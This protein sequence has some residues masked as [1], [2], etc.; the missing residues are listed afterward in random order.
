MNCTKMSVRYRCGPEVV[1]MRMKQ[2][3]M[4]T[5]EFQ[6]IEKCKDENIQH[7][8]FMNVTDVC[9]ISSQ[10]SLWL[11]T[12]RWSCCQLTIVFQEGEQWVRTLSGGSHSA[13]LNIMLEVKKASGHIASLAPPT[14]VRNIKMLRSEI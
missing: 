4:P 8:M 5:V 9:I 10:P 6:H 13:V 7:S 2:H 11:P 1:Q 14:K 3:V 12:Q